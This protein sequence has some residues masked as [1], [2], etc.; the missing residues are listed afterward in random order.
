M[1]KFHNLFGY[2]I[3]TLIASVLATAPSVALPLSPG[4]RVEVS[5][6]DEKYF[7][8]V[9]EVNQ[10]GNLEVPYLGDLS[11]VGLEPRV[12]ERKL[13]QA[14]INE[15]YFPKNSLKLSL[16]VLLWAPVEVGISGEVFSPGRVIINEIAEEDRVKTLET[17][18]QLIAGD[19]PPRRTLTKAIRAAGGVTPT[20]DISRVRLVR[21]KKE[22]IID[23]TGVITGDAI[24]N[25]PVMAGD[26]I[27]I[28]TANRHQPELVRPSD[29]TLS[30]IKIF[31]SNLT[32]PADNN[33]KS[34]IGN[35]KEGITVP[36]GGRFSQAVVATNCVGGTKATNASRKAIL[37]RVN[38]ISGKTA[39][40]ERSVEDLIRNSTN[41]A[42]NPLLMP[43]DSV[44]CYDSKV[45]NTRDVF[46][47][48]TDVINPLKLIL[49]VIF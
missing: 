1:N 44:A 16:Q 49:D 4:D 19:Y 43:R 14:L 38:R 48:I 27:I 45:T 41:E 37:V 26:Q 15:G 10:E 40:L 23:L 28:P 3:A 11:V 22:K 18:A 30:G 42:E 9:Y 31:V 8:R 7:A 12:A 20:A 39:Y 2:S 29:I 13:S 47:S 6:P 33:A 35:K 5:I 25:V 34:D 21:D 36:Y 24:E 17:G 46:R 32:I